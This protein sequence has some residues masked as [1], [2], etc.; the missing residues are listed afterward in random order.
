MLPPPDPERAIRSEFD[1]FAAR[2]TVEAYELFIAR[3]P[4]HPLARE[5]RRRI[6]ALRGSDG[7]D[8]NSTAT[9]GGPM[10]LPP[11]SGQ[12]KTGGIMPLPPDHEKAVRFEFDRFAARGTI[13]A[14]EL[15]IARHPDHALAREARRRIAAMRKRKAD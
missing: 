6:D 4:D 14:Y 10:P 7:G 5:A 3:H 1:T 2:G 12:P 9:T 13:E 15:F 11:S 8:S